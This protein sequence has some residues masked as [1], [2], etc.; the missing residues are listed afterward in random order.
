MKNITISLIFATTLLFPGYAFAQILD[1]PCAE[2]AAE[3]CDT[4]IDPG[5]NGSGLFGQD[6]AIGQV[7]Q[8]LAMAAAVVGVVMMIIGGFKFI[9]SGGDASKTSSARNTILYA[10]IGLVIAATAQLIV[11]FVVNKF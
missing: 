4:Q 1:A 8:L 6:A 11:V 5:E 3:I 7:I 10:A 2:V 9:V